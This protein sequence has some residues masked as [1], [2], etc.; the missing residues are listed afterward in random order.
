MSQFLWTHPAY[1]ALR[2]EAV[3]AD[4]ERLNETLMRFRYSVTGDLDA[5]VVPP[6]G[7]PLRSNN[8]W[9]TTC[10]EAFLKP[11]DGETYREFNFSPS[12]QWAAFDFDGYRNLTGNAWL[13]AAPEIEVSRGAKR[14]ELI[15]T[16]SLDLPE[17]PYRL[18]LSAVIEERGCPISYWALSHPADRPDF[19]ADACFSLQLPPAPTP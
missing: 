18:G 12:G 10:F 16:L 3:D 1:C 6:S 13:P 19:H 4:V 15:A 9:K 14:L 8:L 5:L 17:E 11:A 7:E 2:I